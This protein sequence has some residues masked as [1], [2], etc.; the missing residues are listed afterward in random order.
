MGRFVKHIPHDGCGS[1][2]GLGV[3]A[4]GSG[5][6]F[7]CDKYEK[8]AY[9]NEEDL[10]ELESSNIMGTSSPKRKQEIINDFQAL[11]DR[12]IKKETAE[13]Y[14]VYKH[15]DPFYTWAYPL[16]R[17]GQ[18]IANKMRTAGEK[19]GFS[20][21]GDFNKSELFGQ[22]VFPPGSSKTITVTEGYD[23]AMAAFELQGSKYPCVSVHSSSTARKDCAEN[24][25]YLNSFNEI[26]LCFD[27]DVAKVGPDGVSH[28][29]GQEAAQACAALFP[30]KKVRVLTLRRAK[31]AND[32]LKAGLSKEFV[33][34]W[35][36]A[37]TWTPDGIVL[38]TELWDEISSEDTSESVE[39]PFAGLN[40]MTYGMRLGQLIVITADTGVGKTSVLK[41][42]EHY[43]LNHTA[44]G[45]G[46]MHLEESKKDTG[47]GIMSIEANKPLH[48]PDIRAE[49]SKDELRKY[50]DKTVNSDRVIIYDHF[51][52]NA[53][54]DLLAKIRHMA[55]MGAK[56]IV[57]D[58]LSIVVS[59]QS[60]DERK[61]LDEISTKIKTL[62]MELN[63]CVIA[64]IHQ[65]RQG[66]IRGTA[67][68]EQLANIV[69]KLYRDKE[70]DDPWMRNVTKVTIQKNRFC[71][72][73]GPACYLEY[74]PETGRLQELDK[75]G[76]EQYE[77]GGSGNNSIF[78]VQEKWDE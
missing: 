32:Y 23:D 17:N 37:P 33:D 2:D 14:R 72:R 11:T 31:D 50:Y 71:G 6:C 56:F 67:G 10:K 43:L 36:R 12:G 53:I 7:V 15:P 62:T 29:P 66:Q 3:Y 69:I 28:Y 74:N 60:G 77:S 49:V 73:T 68:V 46:I 25:E 5:Y 1:S 63:I 75:T 4:D 78:P 65:N 42:I 55:A 19:K 48:L 39:Y 13:R 58:H 57:L 70:N 9:N 18:H 61:Q 45:L 24:F 51:G 44:Y 76:I 54:D 16:F 20:V 30:A 47:L 8:N 21:D 41:E 26:I 59:D 52:S 27:A 22:N 35:W 38:G 40:E 34:E 64:V